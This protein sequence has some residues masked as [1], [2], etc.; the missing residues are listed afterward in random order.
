MSQ[1]E[2]DG[3]LPILSL[4]HQQSVEPARQDGSPQ[5]QEEE[6]KRVVESLSRISVDLGELVS[7]SPKNTMLLNLVRARQ[8]ELVATCSKLQL[9][10]GA[11][12]T[13][14]LQTPKNLG[15]TIDATSRKL[16]KS[17]KSVTPLVSSVPFRLPLATHK[18]SRELQTSKYGFRSRTVSLDVEVSVPVCMMAVGFDAGISHETSQATVLKLSL[19]E[20]L[21]R[22][23]Y[24]TLP[25][26]AE[27]G[28][29]AFLDDAQAMTPED[30]VEKWGTHLCVGVELGASYRRE[31]NEEALDGSST[32][33]GNF[34][35]HLKSAAGNARAALKASLQERAGF[36]L[37]QEEI[38]S[39]SNWNADRTDIIGEPQPITFDFFPL[40]TFIQD[41]QLR[42]NVKSYV[43][44]RRHAFFQDFGDENKLD[45]SELKCRIIWK[46]NTL[47]FPSVRYL[48]PMHG[49]VSLEKS[50]P[51]SDPWVMEYVPLSDA[52]SV[53]YLCRFSLDQTEGP[54]LSLGHNQS[55]TLSPN[56]LD[57]AL[58]YWSDEQLF[59]V[60]P[61]I[62]GDYVR[63]DTKKCLWRPESSSPA[64][65]I[66]VNEEMNGVALIEEEKRTKRRWKC[67]WGL[68]SDADAVSKGQ[69][70]G[71]AT[72][73][74]YE[75]FSYGASIKVADKQSSRFVRVKPYKLCFG[76]DYEIFALD[77]VMYDMITAYLVVTPVN[78]VSP[79]VDD[80][81]ITVVAANDIYTIRDILSEFNLSPSPLPSQL[82]KDCSLW[83]SL[84][85]ENYMLVYTKEHEYDLKRTADVFGQAHAD[86]FN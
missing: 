60:G 29:K 67:C 53:G 70:S 6:L 84:Y 86:Y 11:L 57:A 44:R 5:Q 83:E 81:W 19:T 17:W 64:A 33:S 38:S 26:T 22:T 18:Y 21:Y 15:M 42:E 13:E 40:W 47:F 27:T 77:N 46:E 1:Q 32:T 79:P 16:E 7:A 58:F 59:P 8:R 4:A 73:R 61:G 69:A 49:A 78:P 20:T 14:D 23:A 24:W 82:G 39:T 63:L 76:D 71:L 12:L 50:K 2:V 66:G 25:V 3:A 30:L 31:T 37:F 55:L 56:V 51:V 35:V 28:C 54:W 48:C 65:V 72:H 68:N 80:T 74:G 9:L 36:A 85:H 43:E 45:F 62:G 41:S 10:G 52:R 75:R 34:G